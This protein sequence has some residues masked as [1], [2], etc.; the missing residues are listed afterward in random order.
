[1]KR[2]AAVILL[3]ATFGC[4]QASSQACLNV[5]HADFADLH[6]KSGHTMDYRPLKPGVGLW[7]V[8]EVIVGTATVEDGPFI[9]CGDPLIVG[10]LYI[11]PR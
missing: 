4:S 10:A 8:D 7:L 3:G 6:V 11:T 1:M 9:A 5:P 2:L